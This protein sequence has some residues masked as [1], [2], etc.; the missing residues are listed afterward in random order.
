MPDLKIEHHSSGFL[1]D[2]EY[3]MHVYPILQE[4]KGSFGKAA[5]LTVHLNEVPYQQLADPPKS[6]VTISPDGNDIVIHYYNWR[7]Y[8]NKGRPKK[9][10]LLSEVLQGLRFWLDRAVAD[11]AGQFPHS[12]NEM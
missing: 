5:S 6:N 3:R 1:K 4:Y 11:Y 2:A 10:P 7:Y 8:D 12:V 9:L